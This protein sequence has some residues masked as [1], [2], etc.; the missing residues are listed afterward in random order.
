[1]RLYATLYH[2]TNA[3]FDEVDLSYGQNEGLEFGTGFYAT[4]DFGIAEE[5]A[6]VA[7]VDN[8]IDEVY[9]HEFEFDYDE[10]CKHLS[11]AD[12]STPS[13]EWYHFVRANLRGEPVQEYDFVC[14]PLEDGKAWNLLNLAE[15]GEL[16]LS[17]AI[18]IISLFELPLQ[19]AIK[20]EAAKTYL[21]KSDNVIIL[22]KERK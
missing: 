16:E 14:G 6:R 12:F 13:L 20:T 1:M 8:E 3:S 11:F 19:I 5:Y 2:G 7:F 4:P 18:D 21:K 9:I 17:E 15:K 10:A 22:K